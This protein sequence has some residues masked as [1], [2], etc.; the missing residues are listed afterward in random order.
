MK[1][2]I[3]RKNLMRSTP[4]ICFCIL[5][6]SFTKE[7]DNYIWNPPDFLSY[8]SNLI[9][10]PMRI[11]L[12][13][14]CFLLALVVPALAQTKAPGVIKGTILDSTNQ[15][16]LEAATVTVYAVADTTLVNYAITDKKG[17][18][19]IGRLPTTQRLKVIVTYHGF[20][21]ATQYVLLET[22]Y[23][24]TDL[25][26]ILLSN[27]FTELEQ[28]VV[29][30][31]KPPV[32]YRNDTIEFNAGSFRTRPNATV[33]EL[34][35]KLPGVEVDMDGNITVNGRR[36]AKLTV[37]GKMFFGGDP[38]IATRNLPKDIV[39]KIQVTINRS[40]ESLITGIT[41][42]TEDLALNIDLDDAKSSGWFGKTTA[43]YGTRDR[44]DLNGNFHYFNKKYQ[45]S[46][47]ASRNN[48][49]GIGS[50]G[51][52]RNFGGGNTGQTR[53]SAAGLNFSSEVTD[54]FQFSGS[55][56]LSEASSLNS[57]R[58]KR[59]NIL[60]DTS[61]FYNA[62]V[63]HKNKSYSNQF[64]VDVNYRM[65]SVTDLH[66]NTNFYNTKNKSLAVSNAFSESIE[67]KLLN[68]SNTT[69][70]DQ[71][72][73]PN[74]HTNLSFNRRLNKRGSGLTLGAAWSSIADNSIS[75]TTGINAFPD[76]S[77]AL[78]NDTLNQQ[79]NNDGKSNHINFTLLWSEPLSKQFN[80][81]TGGHISL[82]SGLSDRNTFSI[83]P[84]TGAY[85]L[86]DTA[87]SNTFKNKNES[88]S[89]SV[90]LNYNTKKIRA[91][92]SNGLNFFYQ[93]NKSLS[94]KRTTDQ[95]YVNILPRASMGYQFD[96]MSSISLNYDGSNQPPSIDQLQPVTDNRNPLYIVLGNPD[97]KPSF[98]HSLGLNFNLNK[99]AKQRSVNGGIQFSSIQNQIVQE[100]YF[101]SIG[102]Q[103][104]RPVNVDG[105]YSTSFYVYY[106]RGW[107]LGQARYNISGNTSV[108]QQVNT[109]I[110]NKSLSKAR[111]YGFVQ[112]VSLQFEQ[113]ELLDIQLR[114]S[115]RYSNSNYNTGSL[116]RSPSGLSQG[117]NLG[118]TFNI[119]K[120]I[121]IESDLASNYNNR[122]A[123]GFRKTVTN[124]QAGANWLMFK[125]EQG[126]LRLVVYD[127][128]RQNASVSRIVTQTFIEDV[129]RLVLQQYFLLSFTYNMKHFGR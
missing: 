105:N 65:D 121:I 99:Y 98:N 38:L 88:F 110:S 127:L 113:E 39:D 44:Y 33:E 16:P 58:S 79:M 83:D 5:G 106:G 51:R 122:I 55:Y 3:F 63:S 80:I 23:P 72:N 104:S 74:L 24:E 75:Y 20:A 117:L 49:N 73:T 1:T 103:I 54:K 89:P 6:R 125:N 62:D 85:T 61:F 57:T 123:P 64:S 19:E 34:L 86:A 90:A 41:D 43:G 47:I 36:V 27:R 46:L 10:P 128:L 9:L 124:W 30:A 7:P 28:V 95:R 120:R 116:R 11:A 118:F 4:K 126:N 40:R 56:Y 107:K 66:I 112:S 68:V 12:F 48:I 96:E 35:K 109:V 22:A 70:N 59:Q 26:N 111:T 29:T 21:A 102:R 94:E 108:N 37:N 60:P 53:S 78:V 50:E 84:V 25:Q 13:L 42:G 18:F 32:V 115:I 92:I 52:G 8:I 14:L 71:G 2:P 91:T 31:E 100:I 45:L 87:L 69:T 15:Q 119:T 114:Y 77:G 17:K 82:S 97:L 76:P 93:Q 81:V 67:G 101:D 129:D